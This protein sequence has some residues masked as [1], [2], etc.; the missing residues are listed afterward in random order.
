MCSGEERG[1]STR[2]A[3]WAWDRV[4]AHYSAREAERG[5]FGPRSSHPETLELLFRCAAGGRYDGDAAAERGDDREHKDYHQW[6]DAENRAWRKWLTENH[7]KDHEFAKAD[8]KEQE[9]Y[10]KWRHEH[11]TST[12]WG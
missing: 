10:W 8:R 5:L 7:R 12:K 6:D 1:C 11:P 4:C 9:E 2:F 3:A